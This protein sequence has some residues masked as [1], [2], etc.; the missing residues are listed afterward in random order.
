MPDHSSTP[1]PVPGAAAPTGQVALVLG[2]TGRL[3]AAV[4]RGLAGRGHSLAI[5]G[6]RG[7]AAARTTAE[8]LAAAGLP[9]LAVT[10]NLRDEGATRTAVHRVADHF[11]RIDIL[12]NC[13]VM[14]RPV[15]L[16]DLAADDLQAH[17]DVNVVA[18]CVA[19][20]EAG[21]LMTRQADG[22][23][24][25][26]VA[27]AGTGRVPSGATAAFAS[28]AAVPALARGLAAEYAAIGAAVRVNCV[29]WNGA[30]EGGM[31]PTPAIDAVARAIVALVENRELSGTCLTL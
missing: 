29:L 12:V 23:T 13:A 26:L 10:A 9:S 6:H 21:R 15:A 4:V 14:Q 20:L 1:D 3:G 19:A 5:H 24:I 2:G 7:L 31:E 18:P 25:L 17:Y 11:G 28:Q 27:A 16:D 30:A 22:G 8:S